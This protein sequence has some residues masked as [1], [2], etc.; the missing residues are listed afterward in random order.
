MATLDQARSKAA[1]CRACG[2]WRTASQTVFGE[3]PVPASMMLVGEQPGDQEDKDGHPFVGPAG[4]VLDQALT[5]AGIERDGVYLTNAV[6]HF[7][8]TPRGKRR[9]HDKPN[10]TEVVACRPWLDRELEVVQP[11][12]LVLLGATA[13]QAVLGPSFRVTQSR[14]LDLADTGL[15]AH[16]VAT[17]HP[18]AVL[19][20]SD[21]E[22]AGGGPAAPPLTA[23][24]PEARLAPLPPTSGHPPDRRRGPMR[25]MTS[26]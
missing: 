2:L 24:A 11:A 19:R 10:R 18:S 7:K 25:A 21:A 8:W 13:S 22:G 9:I 1:G 26:G 5:E 14:G 12:V 15:A 3:G 20:V 6:K 16:V 17:V 4:R 23:P